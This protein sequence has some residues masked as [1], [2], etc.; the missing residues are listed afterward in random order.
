M[1]NN[2]NAFSQ[3]LHGKPTSKSDALTSENHRLVIQLMSLRIRSNE[4]RLLA[5]IN[6][7]EKPTYTVSGQSAKAALANVF[8]TNTSAGNP[9]AAPFGTRLV[10]EITWGQREK[11]ISN[12]VANFNLAILNKAHLT[13][14]CKMDLLRE[15]DEL[16]R[17]LSTLPTRPTTEPVDQPVDTLYDS[18]GEWKCTEQHS[19]A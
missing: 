10:S 1:I 13:D 15:N 18:L 6:E 4:E 7:S 14:A 5:R 19:V 12:L 8:A 17:V 9:S 11:I 2:L 3:L 16:V